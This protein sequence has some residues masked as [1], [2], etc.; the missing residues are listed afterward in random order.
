[1]NSKTIGIILVV[2]GILMIIY[3]GFHF[4]TTEKLVDIGPIEIN[5][6][7]NHFVQWSPILGIVLLGG[8]LLLTFFKK[9]S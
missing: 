7:K 6:D 2:A 3:T 5:K 1:M 4:V 8:G 9:S